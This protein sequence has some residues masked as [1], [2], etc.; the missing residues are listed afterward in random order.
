MLSE[1]SECDK[2]DG[3]AEE[4]EDGV[5]EHSGAHT[6]LL[7][8][9]AEGGCEVCGE[10]ARGDGIGNDTDKLRCDGGAEVTSCGEQGI[11][12]NARVL[13]VVFHQDEST[14]PEHRREKADE[15]AGDEGEDGAR[16]DTDNKVADGTQNH[17]DK[18]DGGNLFSKARIENACESKEDSKDGNA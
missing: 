12:C 11:G 6:E 4:G 9:D 1:I 17:S 2:E 16:R 14:W 10:V 13:D 3:D 8:G 5:E 18:E 15:D 7:G